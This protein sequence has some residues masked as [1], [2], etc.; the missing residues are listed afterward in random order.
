M[1]LTCATTQPHTTKGC[2]GN[3]DTN[4]RLR[5]VKP[6]LSPTVTASQQRHG[7]AEK[8][9]GGWMGCGKE[10]GGAEGS[11][12]PPPHAPWPCVG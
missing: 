11:G 1:T 4:T 12:V 3:G 10:G 2:G 7:E 6:S 8:V 9:T 5:D